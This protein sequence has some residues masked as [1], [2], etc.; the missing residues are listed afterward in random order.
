MKNTEE[1]NRP[2]WEVFEW[3]VSTTCSRYSLTELIYGEP[4]CEVWWTLAPESSN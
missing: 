4:L 3:I 1:L 2:S